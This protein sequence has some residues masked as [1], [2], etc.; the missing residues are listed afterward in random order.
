MTP[1]TFRNVRPPVTTMLHH[2]EPNT[3]DMHQSP[4]SRQSARTVDD[5]LDG[6]ADTGFDFEF[7]GL[8]ED[9]FLTPYLGLLDEDDD[10]LLLL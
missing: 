2:F 8:I 10:T 4:H 5:L 7:R 6:I 1:Q 3:N 9:V